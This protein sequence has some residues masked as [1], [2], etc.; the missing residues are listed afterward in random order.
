MRGCNKTPSFLS[1]LLAFS[2]IFVF[3][4]FCNF[5]CLFQ[6]FVWP[7]CKYFLAC[8]Q[9]FAF[10]AEESLVKYPKCTARFSWIKVEN[11]FQ[12]FS[13]VGE[14]PWN[15]SE[16]QFSVCLQEPKFKSNP[17]LGIKMWHKTKTFG[18]SFV[19][20][21]EFLRTVLLHKTKTFG[22]SFDTSTETFWNRFISTALWAVL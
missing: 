14:F 15:N 9:I 10:Y 19:T 5:F 20:S 4:P 18:S 2:Q 17:A 6:I 13:K 1:S 7:F 16:M 12:I 3:W 8:L 22:S 11:A 21:T